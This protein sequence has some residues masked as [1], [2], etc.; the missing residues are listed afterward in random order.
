MAKFYGAIGY[1]ETTETSPGVY[2]DVVTERQYFGDVVKNI[3]RHET[4]EN[5]NDNITV[6]NQL[7]IIADPFAYNHFHTMRYV[8][9]MGALWKITSVDVQRPRL[10]LTIGG[11]YNGPTPIPPPDPEGDSGE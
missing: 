10:V 7:S 11:V 5:L 2:V 9:W 8:S 3:A 1:G 4:G 6:N